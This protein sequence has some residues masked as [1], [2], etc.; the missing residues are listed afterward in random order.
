METAKQHPPVILLLGTR[1]DNKVDRWLEGSRF[2][3]AEVA[4]AFQALEQISDFTVRNTP[5]VIFLHVDSIAT[6][7]EF[8]KTIVATDSN[9]HDVPIIGF[10]DDEVMGDDKL[11]ALA[12][13][14]GQLIPQQNAMN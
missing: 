9:E 14:L 7:L 13:R 3:T 2:T 11:H 5:D 8:L 12:S 1:K 10:T 4:D 6:E